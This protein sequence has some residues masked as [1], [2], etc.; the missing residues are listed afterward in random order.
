MQERE[1]ERP[2]EE[3]PIKIGYIDDVHV[4]HIDVGKSRKRLYIYIY[5]YVC[6]CVCVCEYMCK[7]TTIFDNRSVPIRTIQSTS[8][9]VYQVFCSCPP[10]THTSYLHLD[11]LTSIYLVPSSSRAHTLGHQHRSQAH[12]NHLQG[13]LDTV[14]VW[15]KC[16]WESMRES[17]RRCVLKCK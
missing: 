8:D 10:P 5:I 2:K 7:R 1:R 17:V 13:T 9:S 3:L 12:G 6:V 16:V 4:Y 11:T 14:V 15:F